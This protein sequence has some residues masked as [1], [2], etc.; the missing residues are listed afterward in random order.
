MSLVSLLLLLICVGCGDTI[1]EKVRYNINEPLF[2]SMDDFR[3]S[4]DIRTIPEP[5][6]YRGKMCFYNDYM[7]ISEPEKGIHIIDNRNPSNPRSVG[8]IELMGNVDLSIRA[9]TLYADAYIDLVWFDIS[10][11]AQPTFGGRLENVFPYAMPETNNNDRIDYSM[12]EEGKKKNQVVVGWKVA[13]R[14]EI[15]TYDKDQMYNDMVAS[16]GGSNTGITGSMA[17]FAIYKDNLYTLTQ[18]VLS[19]F[20]I[21]QAKPELKREGVR[22]GGDVETIF[23]YKEYMFFGTRQGMLIWS[24][25][26]PLDPQFVSGISHIYGCDPVVVENDIAYVT[27]FSGNGCGQTINELIVLDVSN[28]EQPKPIVTYAMKQPKGL[29]IENGILFL[30]DDGL[31]IFDATDP[32]TLMAHQLAHYTGMDGYDVIPYNKVLMMIS[33]KGLHQYD[34]ADLDNI[35][36]LSFFPLGRE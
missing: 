13:R 34:Y 29:A 18:N 3:N 1:T 16:P 27:V 31:K 15:Y 17:A 5:I 6:E 14:E 32:Q 20:D 7:Y 36:E 28:I 25:K 8:F 10:N 33:D 35:T 2:I 4:I 23:S 21:S 19:I 22:I 24:V 30:C 26:D 9:N 11:P 12:C